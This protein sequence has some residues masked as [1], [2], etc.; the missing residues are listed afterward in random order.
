MEALEPF[1]LF[2]LWTKW[3]PTGQEYREM[4]NMHQVEQKACIIKASLICFIIQRHEWVAP[5]D[6]VLIS[7]LVF[8]HQLQNPGQYSPLEAF[9]EDKKA[10]LPPVG[11]GLVTSCPMW[12]VASINRCMH[13]E[14]KV[15]KHQN[16]LSCRWSCSSV[17][18]TERPSFLQITH[19]A[20]CM[21]QFIQFFGEQIMVLWKFVL[22]RKRLLIFSPP[23]IGVV[24]YRGEQ[25]ELVH[26]L[27]LI[28]PVMMGSWCR[29]VRFS[30]AWS[31]HI[32]R[33]YWKILKSA[34]TS[35]ISFINLFFFF[36]FPSVYCCC[37]LANVSIPG[38]GVSVPE[39]RPFF[40]IN[41]ADISALETELSYVACKRLRSSVSG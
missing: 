31:V 27:S 33:F 36:F 11:N 29:F 8:R 9:Y 17:S 13:P 12:S 16:T 7:S 1:D 41:I 19:P 2:E 23:P 24:C 15:W 22:L 10:V 25:L 38:I 21:S 14:M 39:L 37:C 26:T 4:M 20:G 35:I 32:L 30:G 5:D 40:Y 6:A 3:F 28:I 18:F 34:C